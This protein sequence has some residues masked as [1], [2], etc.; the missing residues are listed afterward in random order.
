MTNDSVTRYFYGNVS[1]NQGIVEKIRMQHLDTALT[2]IHVA[3]NIA[4]A[5]KPDI[6]LGNMNVYST[7]EPYSRYFLNQGI[8]SNTISLNPLNY[9]CITFNLLEIYKSTERFEN[10]KN[11][12]TSNFLIEEEKIAL[13]NFIQERYCGMSQIFQDSK[14]FEGAGDLNDILSIDQNKT[15][16]FLFS[17]IFWDV[18]ISETGFLYEDVISWVMDS[19]SI[20]AGSEQ[21]H[22]YIKPHPAEVY[23]SS[24][25]LKGIREFIYETYPLLPTNVTIIHPEYKIKTYDLFPF[26]DFA[27]LYNGNL[28]LEMLLKGI[29][30]VLTG[31]SPYKFLD[32]V[33]KPNSRSHYQEIL[34]GNCEINKIDSL[35]VELFSYFYFIKVFIPWTLTNRAFADDFKGFTFNSLNDLLPG[36][37]KYLDHICNCILNPKH[38]VIEA[39]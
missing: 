35:E 23:D 7:W 19:I 32:S 18:G 24:S 4:S 17:N 22:L 9:S 10:W 33:T 26:I 16:V 36:E 2:G 8:K 12:R 29:P 3:K 21:I 5:W 15:N 27:I 25:S 20:V 34:L 31:L 39:W 14:V 11:R 38:T 13:N 30:I 6:V 1:T 37:D 28:G